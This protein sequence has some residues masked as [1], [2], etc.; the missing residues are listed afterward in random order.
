MRGL[1]LHADD[2]ACIDNADGQPA[3]ETV[4][5]Q[6][7]A[8]DFL[9]ADQH[10][11]HVIVARGE[12]GAFDFGFGRSIGAHRVNS[13]DGG[14]A[15]LV[16]CNFPRLRKP[17]LLEGSDPRPRRDQ[18][19]TGDTGPFPSFFLCVLSASVAKN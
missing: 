13:N 10:H 12:N 17:G 14:H 9:F 8:D 4:Q 15:C 7:G 19:S 11:F 16:S 6:L 18:I 1:F 2:F 5:V 3:P